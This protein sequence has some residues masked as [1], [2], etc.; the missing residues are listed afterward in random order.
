MKFIKL[1]KSSSLQ[2]VIRVKITYDDGKE[3]IG[4]WCDDDESG[5]LEEAKIFSNEWEAMEICDLNIDDLD[6]NE[7]KKVYEIVQVET[8][9][10]L[11]DNIVKI[12]TNK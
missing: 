2:Y 10:N 11:T 1:I 7:V 12:Y 6:N 9:L 4:Y 5:H 8:K 3:Y